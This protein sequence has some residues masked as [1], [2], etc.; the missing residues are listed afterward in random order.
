MV[1]N[2]GDLAINFF[3]GNT[4]RNKKPLLVLLFFVITMVLFCRQSWAVVPY[5]VA[6]EPTSERQLVE[7]QFKDIT[8][9]LQAHGN[10]QAQD[11][12][13]IRG[14][15]QQIKERD[16]KISRDNVFLRWTSRVSFLF[17]LFLFILLL[18]I[19]IAF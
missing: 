1:K 19:R 18:K 16:I 15:L 12:K 2:A 13:E 4:V 9:R 8:E 6:E 5:P 10:W 11:L 14:E 17:F 7:S 3:W